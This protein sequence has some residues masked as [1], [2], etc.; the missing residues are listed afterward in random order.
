MSLNSPP[1]IR[2]PRE[3]RIE[4]HRSH[5]GALARRSVAF[6]L[7]GQSPPFEIRWRGRWGKPCWVDSTE[8]IIAARPD[9]FGLVARLR[10]R[11][12]N[13]M[14]RVNCALTTNVLWL[15]LDAPKVM[16]DRDELLG[17]GERQFNLLEA[18]RL[19][20]SAFHF[21][22]HGCWA[23]WKLS[24]AIPADQA[25]RLMRRL[26]AE[27][28]PDGSEHNIDRLTR[29]PGAWHQD[30]GH[31]AFVMTLT[32]HRWHPATFDRLLPPLPDPV[33]VWL[34]PR[35]VPSGNL[36]V[37]RLPDALA[38]YQSDRPDKAARKRLGIDGS[39]MEQAIVC[40]L[41]NLG[42]PDAEI[43]RYF[44]YYGLPR[45]IAEQTKRCNN[46]WLQLG[47]EKARK[48]YKPP[49]HA[50]PHPHVCVNTGSD[51]KRQVKYRGGEQERLRSILLTV[52]QHEGAGYGQ[53][54]ELIAAGLDCAEVTARR[55]LKQLEAGGYVNLR[56]VARRGS[57]KT[58]WLTEK[59]R[60]ALQ[61][62]GRFPR[63]IWVHP[64]H[65]NKHGTR[66]V[67]RRGDE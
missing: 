24:D 9:Y 29:M 50:S 64:M 14:G 48:G 42:Y 4:I 18:S 58:V 44:D 41:V 34:A 1:A 46:S 7:D 16:R 26:Y 15:D 36:P 25:E 59:G 39:A 65:A 45:H 10:V 21:S 20:P 17:L 28:R 31:Q 22:G 8:E 35:S 30:T 47:I 27:F 3:G 13:G 11:T 53:M 33:T 5:D 23:F 63:T 19:T 40:L 2:S 52:R 57:P 55:R 6:L 32:G 56:S 37:V 61:Q 12:G 51:H 60:C 54:Q 38:A 62:S 43:I 66:G 67:K 49:R